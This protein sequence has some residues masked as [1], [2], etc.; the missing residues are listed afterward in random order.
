MKAI[1]VWTLAGVTLVGCGKN[2]P[3]SDDDTGFIA[4]GKDPNIAVSTDFID[5]G[6]LEV[7]STIHAE[8]DVQNLGASDLHIDEIVLQDSALAASAGP[9]TVSPGESVTID[10]A[11]EPEGP[12]VTAEDLVLYSNDPDTPEAI[13]AVEGLG[14][15]AWLEVSPLEI[16]IDDLPAGCLESRT[17]TL[18]NDGNLDLM[19]DDLIT[20]STSDDLSYTLWVGG[21]DDYWTIAPGAEKTV[22]VTF[23]PTDEADDVGEITVVSNDP[24]GEVSALLHATAAIVESNV[25]VFDVE[26]PTADLLFVIDDSASM[27]GDQDRLAETGSELLFA[28]GLGYTD[29]RIGSITT[30]HPDLTTEWLTEDTVAP[31]ALFE[32]MIVVGTSAHGSERALQQLHASLDGGDAADMVRDGT[33]L[34]VVILSDE[35]EQSSGD[36]ESYVKDILALKGDDPVRIHAIA[37]A[38]PTSSCDAADAGFGF[39]VATEMTG[40]TL[41][42]ICD[43]DFTPHIEAI[44]EQVAP[45]LVYGLTDLPIEETLFVLVDGEPSEGWI[46]DPET[47]SIDFLDESEPSVGAQVEVRY[48]VAEECPS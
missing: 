25:D 4:T 3:G 33:P 18:R 39:D 14:L 1:V 34:T 19:I 13:V 36:V 31:L 5:F 41:F 47:N 10:V 46:Y 8:L 30:G 23:A 37:G 43:E 32:E 22:D 16:D 6:E 28:L 20:T 38:V 29:Y 11:F 26:Q 21:G 44:A 2:K 48:D 42:D 40:G 9:R 17:I 35:P 15:A 24:R 27:W 7:G 12:F 45:P